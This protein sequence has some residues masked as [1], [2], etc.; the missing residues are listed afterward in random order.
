MLKKKYKYILLLMLLILVVFC[1]ACDDE[2]SAK[3]E[4]T[5][6]ESSESK[7]SIDNNTSN[8][9]N[10]DNTGGNVYI[11]IQKLEDNKEN[12][13]LTFYQVE[14]EDNIYRTIDAKE[15]TIYNGDEDVLQGQLELRRGLYR[16]VDVS[17]DENSRA[18]KF[19]FDDST[20]EIDVNTTHAIEIKEV[21][22]SNEEVKKQKEEEE[23]IEKEQREAEEK[24]K[25]EGEEKERQEKEKREIYTLFKKG[26]KYSSA[27]VNTQ[28]KK[29]VINES[30]IKLRDY[31]TGEWGWS[32]KYQ[33]IYSDILYNY[34]DNVGGEILDVIDINSGISDL[35]IRCFVLSIP[36]DAPLV[37]ESVKL[38]K[39]IVDYIYHE[40]SEGYVR[41]YLEA[42]K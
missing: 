17:T 26:N 20:F 1:T 29:F 30:L 6:E 32:E 2:T 22:L 5:T 14:S 13:V 37:G 10:L 3:E 8:N 23:R 35:D 40:L 42:L 31:D 38:N 11:K 4:V 16:L 36:E 34:L 7:T 19:E 41:E 9:T 28:Y 12:I 39:R 27:Q 21:K 24:I 33:N 18:H 25:R 15:I